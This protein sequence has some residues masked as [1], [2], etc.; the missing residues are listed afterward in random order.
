M[1]EAVKWTEQPVVGR[2]A[3]GYVR[4]R[5]ARWFSTRA[6]CQRY[7]EHAVQRST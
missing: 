7:S 4:V 6:S 1:D 5:G 3:H 2:P